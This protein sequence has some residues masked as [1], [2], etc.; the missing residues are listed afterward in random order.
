MMGKLMDV[1]ELRKGII[2]ALDQARKDASVRRSTRDLAATEFEAFLANVAGPVLKQAQD[3]LRAEKHA[4]T[5]QSPTGSGASRVRQRPL[6]ISSSSR[7]MS[8]AWTRR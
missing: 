7:S 8:R 5:Y 4:F 6:A 1:S 2:R 3:V